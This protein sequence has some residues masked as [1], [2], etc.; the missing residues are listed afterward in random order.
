ML[1]KQIV[2]NLHEDLQF[3]IWVSNRHAGLVNLCGRA[4]Q[5]FVETNTLLNG[6]LSYQSW[7]HYS[8][9]LLGTK[10]AEY[11]TFNKM[12]KSLNRESSR[13]ANN[14]LRTYTT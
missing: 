10:I 14:L 5:S 9:E 6:H 8:G 12:I 7:K 1:S 4:I 13:H 2:T 11:R 3:A